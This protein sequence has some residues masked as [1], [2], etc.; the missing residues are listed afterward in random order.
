MPVNGTD[1]RKESLMAAILSRGFFGG[2]V[3]MVILFTG[4]ATLVFPQNFTKV[5]VGEV[6]SDGMRSTGANWIDF[7]GDGFLD[8]FVS[9]GNLNSEANMLFQNN[10]DG[11]FTKIT[12]GDIVTD[13]SSTI[14]S[15]WGDYDSDGDLDV[16][17]TNRSNADNVIHRNEGNAIFTKITEGDVVSDGGDSN[18]SSWIDLDN[19]G[20]LDLFVV[21]FNQINFLYLNEGDGSFTKIDT[22]VIVTESSFSISGVWGDYNNDGWLDLFIG[23][24]GSQANFLYQNHGGGYFTKV[25]SGDIVTNVASGTGCSWGDFNND[26]NLDLFVANFLSADNFLYR[27]DGAPNF[28]F[29]RILDGDIVSDGGNSVGSAWGDVDNDGD[30][31]LFVGDDGGNNLLYLNDGGPDY[32]FTK[33]TTGDIVNDGGNTFGVALGDYDNDGHLDAFATNRLGQNNFLYNNDGNVN[34]WIN[35]RLVGTVSNTTAIAAK[36]SIKALISGS[37]KWQWREITAQSGYNS[38]NSLNAEFGLGDATIIDSLVVR[39]PSGTVTVFTDVSVGQFVTVSED[40]IISDIG[41]E[42]GMS[43]RRFQLLQ[44]HPN[45]F[46]PSTTIT[47]QLTTSEDVNLIIYNML[48]QRMKTVVRQHRQQAGIYH[49]RWNGRTDLGQAAPSGVYVYRIVTASGSRSRKMVLVR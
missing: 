12:S 31:D 33:V 16:F 14:G 13:A 46:N 37:G 35:I 34:S 10:T 42:S 26:G 3:S 17:V 32:S 21:N 30:L 36:V 43:P 6:V 41:L 24:G 28:T 11:S 7:D 39:W 23:N 1:A 18:I 40:G 19:D 47:Y 5:I 4:S 27:N 44:N 49:V 45:P 15:T 22:G 29:T 20:D 38:Q 8:L 9:D 25:T 2:V 48:G